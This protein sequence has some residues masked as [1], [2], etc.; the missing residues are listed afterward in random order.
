MRRVGRTSSVPFQ[1]SSGGVGDEKIPLHLVFAEEGPERLLTVFEGRVCRVKDDGD[2]ADFTQRE[3][4]RGFV[5]GMA[6]ETAA[7]EGIFQKLKHAA[8]LRWRL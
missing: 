2:V 5:A 7:P 3:D 6:P 1:A 4:A 8:P